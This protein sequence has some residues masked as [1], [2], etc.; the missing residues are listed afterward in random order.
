MKKILYMLAVAV[1]A[2]AILCQEA[3]AQEAAEQ[4]MSRKERKAMEKHVA[5]S[6]A[7][8][9]ASI[10]EGTEMT[11]KYT[12]HNF[13]TVANGSDVSYEFEF[14]NTGKA[15][16]VISNVSTSCGCTTPSWPRQPIPS[17]GRASIKVKY[18]SNRIGNFSKTITV[19]SNAKNSPVVL[20]I[21]GSVKYEQK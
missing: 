18:D 4:K 2:T 15:P 14:I 12:D 21:R 16:L 20:S 3:S 1:M 10:V 19:M 11:F 13:G 17:K 6:I 8:L 5:D 9:D 7:A